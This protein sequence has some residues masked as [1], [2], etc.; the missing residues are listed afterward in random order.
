MQRLLGVL[1]RVV[2]DARGDPKRSRVAGDDL[3]QC[4]RDLGRRQA[5]R[6]DDLVGSAGDDAQQLVVVVGLAHRDVAGQAPD[7]VQDLLA[8]SP[9]ARRGAAERLDVDAE[10]GVGRGLL[11][12][13]GLLR[14]GDF[15]IDPAR[16]H[17][18]GQLVDLLGLVGEVVADQEAPQALQR[19][20]QIDRLAVVSGR[21]QRLGQMAGQ[22]HP[23]DR[24]AQ[25][26]RALVVE[27]PGPGAQAVGGGA[28]AV[29]ADQRDDPAQASAPGRCRR[30]AFP[31]PAPS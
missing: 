18:L 23:V 28:N 11:A 24:L 13:S 15:A 8:E 5:E 31:G 10:D 17:R 9:V 4:R 26:A 21:A 30:S 16:R 3:V 25:R 14:S 7:H 6:I 12:Q 1:D 29:D 19:G 2:D 27:R 20:D 22:A